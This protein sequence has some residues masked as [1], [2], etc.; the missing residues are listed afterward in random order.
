M[1]VVRHF[2]ALPYSVLPPFLAELRNRDSV[3]A[4]AL[5]FLILTT[6]RSG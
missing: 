1:R 5:E 6:A 2:A 3:T 4:R